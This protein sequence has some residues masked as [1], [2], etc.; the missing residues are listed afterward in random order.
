MAIA[1]ENVPDR[2]IGE[3][4]KMTAKEIIIEFYMKSI[5]HLFPD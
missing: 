5:F 2:A 3:V 4:I 1:Y